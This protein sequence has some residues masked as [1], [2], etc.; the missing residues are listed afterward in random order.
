M[1]FGFSLRFYYY[2][3]IE[4]K[5]FFFLVSLVIFP[6]ILRLKININICDNV[7]RSSPPDVFLGKGVLKIWNK[8][9][10]EHPSQSE[11]SIKLIYNFIEVALRHGCTRVNLL[12]I[13]EH[14]FI[15]TPTEVCLCFNIIKIIWENKLKAHRQIPKKRCFE[16]YCLYDQ[17]CQFSAL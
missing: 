17:V 14:L 16:K 15:R 11:I 10:G 7:S 8:C 4:K 12:H 3:E 13:S 5:T 2:H 1:I 6:K 9:T